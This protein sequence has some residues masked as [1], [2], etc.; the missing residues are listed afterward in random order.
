M[1]ELPPRWG[2]V[3]MQPHVGLG[4]HLKLLYMKSFAKIHIK[5]LSPTHITFTSTLQINHLQHT[6]EAAVAV[7]TRSS[8]SSLPLGLQ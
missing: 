8:C 6:G 3:G 2:R 1:G 4:S 5:I 7:A